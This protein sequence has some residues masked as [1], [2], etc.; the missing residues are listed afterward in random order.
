ML[1]LR[2]GFETTNISLGAGTFDATLA[3]LTLTMSLWSG[4]LVAMRAAAGALALLP[5]LP[6]VLMFHRF[7]P[8][9]VKVAT[10][11]RRR[12][13]LA[14]VNGWL[15]PLAAVVRPLFGL[16]ARLP[17]LPGQVL[18]DTALTLVM[19]PS[20]LAV[21]LGITLTA[22]VAPVAVLGKLLMAAVA[23]WGVL[24]SD[25]STRDFAATTEELTGA[26]QGGAVR[27]YARQY[28]ATAL[29]GFMFM[30]MIA[31][32]FAPADPVRALAV[33]AGILSLSALAS[34]FGR[35]ARTP[36]LFLALFLF[37]T[38]V[39]TQVVTMPILDMVGFNGV[40]DPRSVLAYCTL[41]ALALAG[42]YL[43]NRRAA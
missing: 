16:A 37:A 39:T 1:L 18:A 5:L 34:L 38:Y 8:D 41:A 33:V 11:A 10:A 40:A 43:W 21:A 28:G 24:V 15:R 32:R 9:L 17:R 2:Q 35:C 25:L 42:G 3:P 19:A 12:S 6:A 23:C 4:K 20:A 27:R 31:L 14:L 13:P 30:G 26:V 22:M 36:R 7:S 29:L